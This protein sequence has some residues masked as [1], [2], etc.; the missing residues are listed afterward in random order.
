MTATVDRKQLI[1]ARKGVA[2]G[3]DF[4]RVVDP[5]AQN[6][7]AV[8]FLNDP[9]IT[10][11][12]NQPFMADR[13]TLEKFDETRISIW[14][15]ERDGR[16]RPV[17]VRSA[18]W[19]V[20]A[21]SNRVYLA[22]MVEEPGGF[23]DY[24]LSLDHPSVDHFAR[25]VKFSFKQG[26]PTDFDCADEPDCL[27]EAMPPV[28]VDYLAR[29]FDSFVRAVMDFTALRFPQWQEKIPAD[30]GV[31]I[32]EVLCAQAD[33][34]SYMQD[35]FARESHFDRATQRR[36]LMHMARLVDYSIDPG[37]NATTLLSF[38]VAASS[39][40][41]SLAPVG[42]R[43]G[44]LA[45]APVEGAKAVPFQL[46]DNLSDDVL[47]DDLYWV[48]PH[49][50]AMPAYAIDVAE[51]CLL[52]GATEM[53]LAPMP[54]NNNASPLSNDSKPENSPRSSAEAWIGRT[55]IL[56][57]DPDEPAR[58]H[59]THAVT[60]TAA[61]I[62]ED[63]VA[64]PDGEDTWQ[65]TRIAW[66]GSQAMPVEFAIADTVVLGNVIPAQAGELV[67]SYLRVGHSFTGDP[68][69]ITVEKLEEPAAVVR[70]GPLY[71]SGIGEMPLRRRSLRH[72]LA[73]TVTGGLAH[74]SDGTP[75]IWID[76]VDGLEEPQDSL[77]SWVW[78]ESLI[79]ADD[80][81][82][83]FTLEP[84]QW[85]DIRRFERFGEGFVHSDYASGDGFSVFFGDGMFGQ[86][87]VE[88]TFFRIQYRLNPGTAGN[89]PRG[90]VNA[91]TDPDDSTA[92]L[93][94]ALVGLTSVE[95]P[96]ASAGGRDPESAESIRR[97]APFLFRET[98][99]RAVV[100]QDYKDILGRLSVIQQAGAPQ[101]WTGSWL[102]R[103]VTADILG[104]SELSAT[105]RS[106]LENVA[107]AVRQAGRDVVVVDPIYR[108]LDLRITLCVQ[109]T[110]VFERVRGQVLQVLFGTDA[111]PG[112]LHENSLSF[113]TP[114]VR[115]VLEAAVHQVQGV[116]GIHQI[117]IRPHHSD[118]I[119]SFTEPELRASGS[120]ILQIRND[121]RYPDHGRVLIEDHQ[122]ALPWSANR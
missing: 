14:P 92:K 77:R 103:R 43:A 32:A 7:L 10:P 49:W 87:P 104:E 72:G 33:E 54:D 65:I 22:V 55:L 47:G 76:E 44:V 122:T 19:E 11:D 82:R 66:D 113:G 90:A 50:N 73:A 13:D 51:P 91:L 24:W 56:R 88:G 60:I 64:T 52:P 71:E 84:G 94:D 81:M 41:L 20:D 26:C 40:G 59:Q 69:E 38:T 80:Q 45:W 17:A 105:N 109:E 78:F 6:V 9:T 58:P 120:E 121:P 89:L 34:F 1:C 116:A 106:L 53:Y 93:D 118:V 23:G 62:I 46:L 96:M 112:P 83:A 37:A 61:E 107:G 21:A 100:E 75:E 86:A 3:L 42:P 115:A 57:M 29:D 85:A 30:L 35:R 114:L 5:K 27:D 102:T 68:D 48:H 95:N 36:S 25:R 111:N 117:E 99:L 70:E 98:V 18:V 63:P 39:G 2:T 15:V 31:M 12:P 119:R 28:A 67:T 97:F 79:E 101:R 8:F 74:A 108:P 110:A 4:V 16:D